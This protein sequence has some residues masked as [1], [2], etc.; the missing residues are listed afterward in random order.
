M[1]RVFENVKNSKLISGPKFAFHS[2]YLDNSECVFSAVLPDRHTFVFLFHFYDP[3]NLKWS[4]EK[5]ENLI[6][7]FCIHSSHFIK[8]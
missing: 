6:P 5:K 1:N 4:D 3:I 7:K 2:P 8:I